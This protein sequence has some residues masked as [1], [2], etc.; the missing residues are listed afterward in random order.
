MSARPPAKRSDIAG[1]VGG[2]SGPT[3]SLWAKVRVSESRAVV[4]LLPVGW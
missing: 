2:G 3:W 4:E 1:D